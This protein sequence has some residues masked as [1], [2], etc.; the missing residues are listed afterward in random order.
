MKKNLLKRISKYLKG[1]IY[2][3]IFTILLAIIVALAQI[4]IPILFGKSIDVISNKEDTSKLINLLKM[5]TLILVISSVLQWVMM[6]INNKIIYKATRRMR[7]EA[8]IKIQSL[9]LSYL[10]THPSGEIINIIINDVDQF[11]E[12]MI[13][14]FTQFFTGLTTII[15]IIIFMFFINYL[16]SILIIVLTPISILL[17]HFISKSTYKHFNNQSIEKANQTAYIEEM[18]SNLKV[19]KSLNYEET[20]ITEFDKINDKLSAISFKATFISSLVNPTT[21]FV[22]SLIYSAVCLF[23]AIF[24][25]KF[26]DEINNPLYLSIGS[27]STLLSYANQ[28]TKPFN[29]ISGVLTELQN[30]MACINRY[31]SFM[32]QE[33]ELKED[34]KKKL[35]KV[36]GNIKI[37]HVDFGYQKDKILIKD[38]NLKVKKGQR[39]AIVGPTGA[40]KTTLI[41]LLM[42]FYDVNS[43]AIILDDNNIID[44]DKKNLRSHYGMVL[45][46]TWIRN[47]KVIDNI[48]LGNDKY[49]LDEVIEACKMAH[50]DSFIKR[51]EDGYDTIINEEGNLSVGEKQLICIARVMLLKPPMLILDEATSSIDTRTELK[52]QD[53]FKTLM[54]NKTTFIVAHRLS[55]IKNCD[56]IL[57][58]KDGNIIESG[59]HKELLKQQGFYYELYNAQF[60]K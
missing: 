51:L 35:T 36:V 5:A 33:I 11:S 42:R 31:C 6:I 24:V 54:N 39:V 13:L 10:D 1:D 43:G 2:L 45:Q 50:C 3:F 41:N 60:E 44:L 22:N 29:E 59:T 21:R 58:L 27:L 48:R 55:T 23:G 17:A 4:Y 12:G 56:I 26:K 47:A 52:I 57:V 20:S 30:S 38:F 7:S 34:D 46:D 53:A 18:V 9:P 49:S 16:I 15:G 25:L 40:G 28:Y 32:N 19:V 14:L 8:F 37:D